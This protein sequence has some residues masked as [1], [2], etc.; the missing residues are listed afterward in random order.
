[1]SVQTRLFLTLGALLNLTNAAEPFDRPLAPFLDTHCYEC[2]DDSS[3][4]GGLNL[5][6]LGRD[7]HDEAVRAKWVRIFDR[8]TQG[9]MPP[10]DEK[11][12]TD[13]ERTTFARNLAQPLS[14]AHAAHKGTV[15]RRLNRREYQNTMNDLFGTNL[16]LEGMLPEDG[17]SHE[18]DNVGEALGLSQTHLKRYLEAAR[19]V[20]DTVVANQTAPPEVW[21]I[22]CA[23]RSSEIE[24]RI[25]KT[26]K[27]LKDGAIVRFEGGGYPSG[28]LRNSGVPQSGFYKVRVTGY[29][30]QSS[31]PIV[32]SIGGQSYQPGSEKP[33]YRFASFPPD[34]PTTFEFETWIEQRYM[35]VVEPHGIAFPQPRPKTIDNYDGPG[36]AF[37]SATIEG[38]LTR[39]FPLRGH[40]LIFKGIDRREIEPRNPADKKRRYYEPKF[41]VISDDEPG[42]ARQS[43]KRMA[44]LAWRRPIGD[45][46][47]E[48]YL[49]LFQAERDGEATFEQ[50]LR[51]ATSA[52][53]VSPNYL[54]LREPA[55]K[56]DDFAVANRLAYFLTRTAPDAELLAL[57][58][59][60]KLTNDPATLRGQTQRLLDDPRF[61]RFLTDFTES[62][63]N[64]REMDFTVPDGS[65]FPEFD[66]YLRHSMPLE[67]EAFLRE[68]IASNLPVRNIVKSDF[69][70]LNGRLAEHYGLAKISGPE[71]R[72][73]TLPANSARGGFL[74]QG[75][76][77]KVSANGTNTSPVL[78][79]VWVME[80]ILGDPPQP[81]PPGI[82]GVEPDI[83]GAE[84][85]RQILDKHRDSVSCAACHRKI[86]P[87]GFA[88]ECFNP[89]GGFREH[90]RALGAGKRVDTVVR[91]RPV[92]YRIGPKVDASGALPDGGEFAT[93][94]EFRDR[95]AQDEVRLAKAVVRKLLT[96]ATGRELGFSDRP[97]VAKIVRESAADGYK[98]RDL[99]H[100]ITT[101]QIFLEK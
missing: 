18:F 20:W 23:F 76:V 25:G 41:E 9:E 97:E 38:P 67:T 58:A 62:W 91:G 47:L 34:K 46:E 63:L 64:L 26:W 6:Q 11:Q 14:Q 4:K 93:F 17:R 42:D 88:L 28:L 37:V 75:S 94:Q 61:A 15:L 73:V 45:A 22:E 48:P 13:T 96:F 95:L 66:A 92:R 53:F 101:S 56:L 69:A 68:L 51:T 70:M 7:L 72:K 32:C 71:I 98:M 44:S 60:K 27:R 40:K 29:A 12:P 99:I 55:G 3:A 90:F 79:G 87:P 52:L 1:M 84:T 59:N 30:H 33:I 49:A 39:E 50:A 74:S 89:I 10:N 57:A 54:Y 77:L 78:R 85:L 21:T 2:H 5:D 43:L 83:R 82:P 35:L 100:R 31:E 24:N 81:P 65:L 80:R 8:V 86:D 16:D 36:F 19:L